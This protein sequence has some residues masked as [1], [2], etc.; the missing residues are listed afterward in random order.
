MDG[1]TLYSLRVWKSLYTYNGITPTLNA[2]AH[3]RCLQV[4]KEFD[5]SETDPT[6]K[7]LCIIYVYVVFPCGEYKYRLFP[8]KN[9][10]LFFILVFILSNLRS[11]ILLM[12]DA[13]V[14][15]SIADYLWCQTF[16]F[17]CQT[18]FGYLY[19]IYAWPGVY[20]HKHMAVIP[21][22]C[23]N[24]Y[25]ASEVMALAGALCV[26]WPDGSSFVTPDLQEPVRALLNPLFHHTAPFTYDEIRY[27]NWMRNGSCD[28]WVQTDRAHRGLRT[29]I[30][31]Y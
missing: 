13:I 23:V 30:A 7:T 31:S 14:W 10:H 20:C 11:S 25:P 26:R 22:T 24:L 3:A 9:I 29:E 5:N 21:K 8:S 15:Y 17:V 19:L 16:G 27:A 4:H 6:A 28:D 18:Y 12:Q 1:S 2:G